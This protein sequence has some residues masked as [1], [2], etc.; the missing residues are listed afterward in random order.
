MNKND[1]IAVE[2][3]KNVRIRNLHND[4]L[5]P[6]QDIMNVYFRDGKK[7]TLD[8]LS[9][10]DFTDIDYFKVENTKSTKVNVLFFEEWGD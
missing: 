2:I 8:L 5:F 6:K 4:F 10:R 7:R 3:V 9:Q 1:I